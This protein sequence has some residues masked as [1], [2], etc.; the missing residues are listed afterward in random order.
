M[1][2]TLWYDRVWNEGTSL[3]GFED[4]IPDNVFTTRIQ[5]RF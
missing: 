3:E 5:Y 4:D 2:L 1:K